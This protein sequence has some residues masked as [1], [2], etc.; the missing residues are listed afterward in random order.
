MAREHLQILLIEDNHADA[1][2]I[3]EL[4]A[5]VEEIDVD[6]DWASSLSL[7]LD[8]YARGG[9]DVVLLD[10]TLPDSQ[11]LDTLRT[12][13]SQLPHASVVVLTALDHGK[14]ALAALQE[15]AQD[16]L[17]K[18]H[19]DSAGLIRS[20]RYAIERKRIEEELKL[21]TALLSAQ[22]ELC[23]DGILVGDEHHRVVHFNR[24][25]MDLWKIPLEALEAGPDQHAHDIICS[26]LVEPQ[27]F[28]SRLT[29]RDGEHH[30]V[31][32]EELVLKD[33][34]TFECH[35]VPMFDSG[36]RYCGQVWY[37]R[38]I[39]E[40]KRAQTRR[41]LASQILATL[42]RDNDIAQLVKD[43]LRLI[44]EETG[45]EA[46]G[47]RLREGDD[48]PYYESS[49]FPESF[50]EA[51]RHLCT[52]DGD[53][54]IVRGADGR[55]ILECMC[56]NVLCG[57]TDPNLPFFT[58][59]GSF[60]TNCSTELLASATEK[61]R[62]GRMRD[63]C[64]SAG[65]ESLALVPLHSGNEVIGLLQLNDRRKGMFTLERIQFFE[66]IGSSIGIALARQ[67]AMETLGESE[68]KYRRLFEAA[69][70]GVLIL[71]A[72][73][74]MVVDVNPFLIELLGFSREQFLRKKVWELGFL[75]DV[76]ANQANFL[77]LQKKGYVRYEDLPLKTADGRQSHVEFVSNV[78]LVD[79][80]KVIQCNIRDITE[81]K[82]AEEQI[83]RLSR[84]PSENPTPVLRVSAQGVLEYAN[85]GA[86]SILPTMGAAVGGTV[87]AEWQARISETFAKKQPV[88]IEF[89]AGDRTFGATLTPVVGH[90]YVNLYAQDI[91][92]RKRAEEALRASQQIIEGILN[93]IPVRV[94][95]KDKNL[96][97]LGCN[98]PFAR[99]AGFADPKDLI[100]K[101]DYQMG[102][103]DQAELYRGDDRQV[104]ESGCAKLL[105]EEPQTTPEGK[106]I[107]LLSNKLPLRSSTGEISGL[108][109]TYM[110]ITERKLAENQLRDSEMRYRR[111]FEAAKDGVLLLDAETGMVTD[112]NPFLIELL[113]ISHEQFL[114]K[115]VWDL[116]FL[117]DVWANKAKFLEL[118]KTGS[119]R[120]DDL[121]LETADGRKVNVEFVSNIY[122]VDHHNVIQCNIRDI[123]EHKRAEA[124]IREQD[125]EYRTILKTTMEGVFILDLQGRFL[126][127]ND[128]Y[129]NMIGYSREELLRM[130]IPDVEADE[131][132]AEVAANI[133]RIMQAGKARFERRQRRKD[134]T[135]VDLDVSV[136][137]L[138]ARN[139]HFVC[140][141]RD[142]TERKRSEET[143][144]QSE[145]RYRTLV[146]TTG[147]GYV[148][149]DLEG[150]V[151]DANPEYV[152]LSGHRD[153]NEIR[154]RSV[155]EWTADYEKE[156]NVKSV[157][158][159]VKEGQIRNLVLDHV[160]A[161]G[162]VIP[163][164]V[165]A[166]VI[167][168]G[169]PPRILALC[170]DITERKRAEAALRE[171]EEELRTILRTTM[172]GFS[173]ADLQGRYLEVNDTFCSMTG[174]SRDELLRMSVSDLEADETGVEVA[175]QLQRVIEEGKAQFER[176][177]RRK[178][179][180]PMDVDISLNFLPIHGGRLVC[181]IRDIT[182]RKHAE[183]ERAALDAQLRQAQ[184]MESI[185]RLAG[186]VAHDFNNILTGIG[187]YTELVLERLDAASPL[188]EDLGEVQR[189]A[190][191][192]AGLTQQLLAFSR[193]QPLEPR[194][195]NLNDTVADTSKMLKRVIG[196]NIDFHFA[197]APDLGNVRA[198]PGQ[199]EQILMNL[200][201]NSRDAMLTGGKLT[202]E[203]AN[204]EL[205]A[206]YAARHGAV[207]PGPYV[208]LAVSDTGC[209][210]D[211]ATKERL[212]EPFFTTKEKGKGTGLGLA[213][214]YGIV[215]QHGGNI[216]VYS[217]PGKGATLKIYLPRVAEA[218]SDVKPAVEPETARGEEMILVVEDE[219][220]VHAFAERVLKARGY[221]VV[222]A[223]SAEEA[224]RVFL[225]HGKTISLLLTDVVLPG[226]NGR[227]LYDLLKSKKPDLKALYM[228]G[229]ADNAIVHQ[230]VLDAGITFMQKPFTTETLVRKVR[231]VLDS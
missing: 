150:K 18:S 162:K 132:P 10:L 114:N 87:N 187:G 193:R 101:D 110:D 121:P 227:V 155:T 115:A 133:Q 164:E 152:R 196:E 16:Y 212:F 170:R 171:S 201:V 153:L 158:R 146:E 53:G 156:K 203:T 157:A 123:T 224:E 34:R 43:I 74:G 13:H 64:N 8:R 210:M 207:T 23:L 58:A 90:G 97:Y 228:S 85:P 127:V 197:P 15:G 137:F 159:C 118:Q 122:A 221:A 80:Q 69:K 57:R 167:K 54:N 47:L 119:V 209:G 79:H 120:Y 102:W 198:D 172:E 44:K 5:E 160:D 40:R 229:Y 126:E 147:T 180:T 27:D 19:I 52:R 181:F 151:L 149:L 81:R 65:Y 144:R 68:V 21:R 95:W 195:L 215:K 208:M 111:L 145:E 185:G 48:F 35:S 148:I 62:Q 39:T 140:F 51:E 139:G 67:R 128:T 194:I 231:Q 50:V 143:L 82:R 192:A 216:W 205:D 76:F 92:E 38:D 88:N 136:N 75:K 98:T 12:V 182:E 107:T 45:I 226:V 22:F 17:V 225:E 186:G 103:R 112:V 29:G 165:N 11:G 56:G 99:D 4:L 63:C 188:R 177:H 168:E 108:L 33:G 130:S 61:Q 206:E 73:T 117:K 124:A 163:M 70:D 49:G 113:S 84:F 199:I 129:C 60:W 6:M 32:I 55:P 214:V 71:D 41:D 66:E 211:A 166:T 59:G 3:R 219:A 223:R 91:T 184:K 220:P 100:G 125:E 2:L 178:D 24:R 42:N 141:L 31:K 134:G 9:V 217:E 116:G 105:I 89:Q 7:G 161:H 93:T 183:V 36:E 14:L 94:F 191:R 25:F 106:T 189:L 131:K 142:I 30:A 154:G 175:T 26:R 83:E 176:R 213:T 104:I 222:I 46:V 37:F 78:Y 169:G 173:L 218:V 179:G 230:G 200:A 72:E 20:M 202:I 135:L 1:K 190:K 96:V 86:D 28:Y 109:G 174:Y 138:S 204:I 77:E